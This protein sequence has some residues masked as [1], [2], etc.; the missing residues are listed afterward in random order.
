MKWKHGRLSFI[1]TDFVYFKNKK[2]NGYLE[3]FIWKL[4][5]LVISRYEISFGLKRLST[6]IILSLDFLKSKY[7][8]GTFPVDKQTVS[9]NS[10]TWN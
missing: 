5:I 8:I 10:A 6:M 7:L 2:E 9:H 4:G 1:T 3:L